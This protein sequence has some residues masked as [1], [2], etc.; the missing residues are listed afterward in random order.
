[1]IL[2][3]VVKACIPTG[4]ES[5]DTLK[6]MVREFSSYLMCYCAG[7]GIAIGMN[8][9]IC[10]YDIAVDMILAILRDMVSQLVGSQFEV[11]DLLFEI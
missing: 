8:L 2:V 6:T 5:L 9:A 7:Y 1:V 10:G 3:P 4:G 11:R